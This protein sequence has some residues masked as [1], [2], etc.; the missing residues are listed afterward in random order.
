MEKDKDIY[1]ISIGLGWPR[2]DEI[3]EKFPDR[4]IQTEASEQT[5]LDIAVGLAYEGKKPIT[6]TISPFYYRAWETLRTYINKENLRVVMVG[7]GRD[8][9]YSDHGDGF[10][11]D[12]RDIPELFSMLKNI[13]QFYPNN[14][15]EVESSLLEMIQSDKPSLMV[16]RR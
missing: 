10:S 13:I 8:G 4:Y 6:Y 15:K 3:K 7:A 14:K 12:A 16:I 5:A 9:D 2:T 1:F 11:H